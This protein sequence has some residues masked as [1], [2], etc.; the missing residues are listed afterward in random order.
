MRAEII[1]GSVCIG[2]GLAAAAAGKWFADQFLPLTTGN[3]P[4]P[5][6]VNFLGSYTTSYRLTIEGTRRIREQDFSYRTV[7]ADY[8]P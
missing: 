5:S 4:T 7:G 2:L 3:V 1:L 6:F 8:E